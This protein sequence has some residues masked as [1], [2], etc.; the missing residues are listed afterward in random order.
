MAGT[1]TIE[2]EQTLPDRGLRKN[3]ILVTGSH[4]SGSTWVG[5]MLAE[6]PGIG[7]I[8]EPFSLGTSPGV[9]SLPLKYWFQYVSDHN[10]AEFYPQIKRTLE[11]RYDLSAEIKGIRKPRHVGRILRHGPRFWK[12][13]LI[14]GRTLMKDPLAFFSSEW[15]ASTFDMDVV[16]LVRHP[17]AFASSVMK[18]EWNHDFNHFLEQPEM[19]SDLL[20]PWEAE[21][22]RFAAERQPIIE[23]ACL[24]WNIV[25][26]ITLQYRDRHPEWLLYRHEDL[27]RDPVNGFESM[28]Q[29]LGIA[30]TAKTIE[31]I[32]DH[33][34]ER[35]PKIA[36]R[37][38]G[39]TLKLDSKANIASWK[40]RL[41]EDEIDL[42]RT[43]VEDVSRHFYGDEDW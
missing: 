1:A 26:T 3:P 23:Q 31:A 41:S 17:A 7:Y 37:E 13:R 33:T 11:F 14:K 10:A 29:E 40:K 19:M 5:R 39:Q 25:A 30:Y 2:R 18:F 24:L 35:N 20:S 32:E 42:I 15:L 21:I 28:M 38:M 6:A 27:S 36:S 16:L 9:A 8:H 12:H 4:R 43:R 22:E 34:S